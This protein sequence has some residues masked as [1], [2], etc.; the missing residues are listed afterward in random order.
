MPE[1]KVATDPWSTDVLFHQLTVIVFFFSGQC[2]F[3]SVDTTD[4]VSCCDP[5]VTMMVE[6]DGSYAVVG[7]PASAEAE[8]MVIIFVVTYDANFRSDPHGAIRRP[9]NAMNYRRR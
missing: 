1:A 4:T 9:G 3:V 8:G 2:H 7:Q 6:S 5:C